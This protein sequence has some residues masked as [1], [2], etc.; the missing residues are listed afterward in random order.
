MLTGCAAGKQPPGADAA[1]RSPAVAE[2]RDALAAA[3]EAARQGDGGPV[4]VYLDETPFR[5]QAGDLVQARLVVNS[6]EGSLVYTN[7]RNVYENEGRSMMPDMPRPESFRP[8]DILVKSGQMVPGLEEA[9]IGRKIGEKAH[10]TLPPGE[11]YGPRDPAKVHRFPRTRHEK[12][13]LVV[14]REMFRQRFDREAR[15]GAVVDLNPYYT[16]R[17]TAV[18]EDAV[19]LEALAE[20][21]AEVEDPIG[22]TRI[23]VRGDEILLT[24]TP[25]I[26]GAFQIGKEAGRIVTA[27]DET[28]T[29]DTNH[30]LSGA[31]LDIDF[32]ITGMAKRSQWRD[33]KID[34]APGHDEGYAV[35]AAD[36]KPQVMVLYA[37]WCQWSQELLNGVF[38]DPRV[39]VLR[40]QFVWVKIDS[41]RE[42]VYK[43]YYRQE[44][45]PNILILSPEGEIIRR[46]NRYTDPVTLNYALKAS[47]AELGG[48]F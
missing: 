22:T 18:V 20:D 41:D 37:S 19:Y 12:R 2:A 40:D 4:E 7:I 31:T 6:A 48:D 8:D 26:G 33:W 9:L 25:R 32:E 17:V 44:G 15:V 5:V 35:A 10:V 29:V 45:F 14:P 28:F 47:L 16:H 23:T 30:P 27:N 3:F 11:A 21:G 36:H 46:I 24:L 43:E 39:A 13:H 1:P 34:W 38:A 42:P